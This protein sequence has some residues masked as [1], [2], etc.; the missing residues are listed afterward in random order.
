MPRDIPTSADQGKVERRDP[1]VEAR[2]RD[3]DVHIDRREQVLLHDMPSVTN[4]GSGSV[5][6]AATT[7]GK[8]AAMIHAED[9]DGMGI[10][11]EAIRSGHDQRGSGFSSSD[12]TSMDERHLNDSQDER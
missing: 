11:G 10:P 12:D 9:P 6:E 7:H 4:R 2:P 8:S 3:E 5:D 1:R